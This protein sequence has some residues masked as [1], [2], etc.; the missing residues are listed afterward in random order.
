[1]P[2][3]EKLKTLFIVFKTLGFAFRR[4]KGELPIGA[5]MT[6]HALSGPVTYGI[7]VCKQRWCHFF[8]FPFFHPQFVQFDMKDGGNLFFK[9]EKKERKFDLVPLWQELST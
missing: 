8:S 4:N 6:E 2:L 5:E 1:M 7:M 3:H 9:G